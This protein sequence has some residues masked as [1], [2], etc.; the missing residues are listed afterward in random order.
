MTPK[1]PLLQA[2]GG[3]GWMPLSPGLNTYLTYKRMGAVGW[4]RRMRRK[5]KEE[6]HNEALGA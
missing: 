4:E 5:G 3:R 2:K 6:G 1:H